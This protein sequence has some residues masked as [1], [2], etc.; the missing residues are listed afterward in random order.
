MKEH[1]VRHIVFASTSSVYGNTTKLPFS[2]TATADRPVSIYAATK[3]A[4]ELMLHTYAELF[5]F[6]VTCLRFFTVYGPWGRP[7]MALFK[8]TRSMLHGEPIEVYNNG[9]HRRDFTYIDDIVDGFVRALQKPQHYEIINLG[10][11]APVEL[12][13]YI[14]VLEGELGITAEKKMLP[15]QEGDVKETFADISK[16]RKLLG[17]EPKTQVAEGVKNFVAWYKEFYVKTG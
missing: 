5:G 16:A 12:M 11:N 6:S 4:G 13:E 10:N 1:G 3:R 7:D 15:M 17:Y 14:R 8:F 2:E 9:E